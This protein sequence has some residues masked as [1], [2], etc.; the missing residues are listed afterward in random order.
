MNVATVTSPTENKFQALCL[1]FYC[2]HLGLLN[3]E[4]FAIQREDREVSY[5]LKLA[6]LLLIC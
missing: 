1:A 3:P 2:F 5:Q 6:T 4:V